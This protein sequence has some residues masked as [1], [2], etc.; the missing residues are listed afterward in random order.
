LSEPPHTPPYVIEDMA[1]VRPRRL[2]TLLGIQWLATPTA[3]V[4]VVWMA[5]LGLVVGLLAEAGSA[6]GTRLLVG[7]AYAVLIFASIVV[8]YLGGA[9]AGRLVDAPMRRVVFT[10]TLAYN[11][12]DEA[13]AYPS[14]V[15]LLRSL[16][17][18]AANLLLGA[19]MLGLY[20]AG[21]HGHLVLFLAVLNLAF[22]VIALAP[23]PT[24]HGGVVLK[25]LKAEKPR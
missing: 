4:A 20:L 16:G 10:A 19:V 1:N 9:L 2:F 11:V 17:E 14:R 12:Y 7:L 24:M 25:Y 6:A 5:A 15:H 3:W 23:F 21:N 18:P 13:R 8:H 22:F